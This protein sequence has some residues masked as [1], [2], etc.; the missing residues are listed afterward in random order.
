MYSIIYLYMFY[1]DKMNRIL[2]QI[3][4]CAPEAQRMQELR[5]GER[6]REGGRKREAIN[7]T[8]FFRLRLGTSIAGGGGADG[9]IADA[10]AGGTEAFEA[11]SC[12][13]SG[14]HQMRRRVR[15]V[16]QGC[17]QWVLYNFEISYREIS[18]TM[19]ADS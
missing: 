5:G 13:S 18:V 16:Q 15:H 7:H 1:A 12:A 8:D 19:G 2:E 6:G 3:S 9:C 10:G 4:G 11:A 14:G 17:E